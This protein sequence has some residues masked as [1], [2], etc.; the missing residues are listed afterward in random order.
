MFPLF[1][2]IGRKQIFAAM[3]RCELFVRLRMRRFGNPVNG[4]TPILD[5]ALQET[6]KGG[7][8]LLGG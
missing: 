6:Q 2:G 1:R 4:S 7:A 5:A 8:A 3:T